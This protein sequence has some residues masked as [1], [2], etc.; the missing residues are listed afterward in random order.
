VS[1]ASALEDTLARLR[2]RYALHYYVPEDARPSEQ[3]TVLVTLSKDAKRRYQEA[4]V[5]YRR[6]YM[7]GNS[8][9]SGPTVVTHTRAPVEE[10]SDPAASDSQPTPKRRRVAV[11]EDT[12]GPHTVEPE[13][14]PAS[15]ET[16]PAPAQAA[17][18][19]TDGSQPPRL[20]NKTPSQGWPKA[21]PPPPPPNQ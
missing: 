17:P 4:D 2:Q 16:D 3:R 20:N 21:D 5:R 10:V 9:R 6:V 11:N 15:P 18:P 8:E 19:S 13:P 12:G 1:D 14:Q 7:A